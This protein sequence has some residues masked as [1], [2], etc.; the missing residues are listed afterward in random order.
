[1]KKT[2]MIGAMV[3]LALL[4]ATALH[5]QDICADPVKTAAGLLQ[6]GADKT[7]ATC[8]WLG[9]PYAAAPV[10]ELRWKAPAPA[11]A[12]SG[13]RKA[14][15]FGARCMQK[16]MME[17]V[18]ADPSKKMSEDCLFLNVWRPRKSGKF[19]VMVWIHGGGLSGG[20]GNSDMYWGDRMAEAGDVVVV[21]LNYRLHVFGFLATEAARNEDPNKSTGN[22]GFLDQ[23]AALKWVQANI[24]GFGGDP[25]NVTIFGESAGGWSVCYHL[26][27]PLS[28]GLFHRA[29]IES[30]GC[31]T[32]H[33]LNQG[34]ALSAEFAAAVGC[35]AGDLACL[36]KL[37]AKKL[38]DKSS[39]GLTAGF[40][41]VAN[42]DGYVLSDTPLNLIKAGNY[43]NVPL[44]AGFNHTEIKPLLILMPK[45]K[46]AK[47][48]E[49]ETQ[50]AAFIGVSPTEVKE[51]AGL[52]PLSAFN[53]SPKDAYVT[54]GSDMVLACPTW[55]GMAASASHQPKTFLYRFDYDK[56]NFGKRIGA[57]HAMEMPFVFNS[58]D[59]APFNLLYNKSKIAATKDLTHNMQGY[60]LNFAKTGDP[61]GPGLPP[62]PAFDAKAPKA[63]VLN[64]ETR[65]ES[66]DIA[67]RCAYWENYNN[68]QQPLWETLGMKKK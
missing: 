27:S 59:R 44:I 18:N 6:G 39:K 30:G 49:Y 15:Q 62:W 54:M 34:Y 67:A 9:V 17:L 24:A 28:K 43:N 26:A 31:Q 3:M 61:N 2:Y 47:P 19:P 45:L 5:A 58:A 21:S 65:T 60:W 50:M 25:G 36:R 33:T 57:M 40:E 20:T 41:H 1:M 64:L 55:S 38:N 56:M 52:Y 8:S 7:T 12:W 14:D 23:N 32:T 4:A 51:V 66:L 22:Y 11:P 53:N 37:S 48:A 68:T 13:V 29:I 10:G 42:L 35:P 46:H 63:Q 16:G